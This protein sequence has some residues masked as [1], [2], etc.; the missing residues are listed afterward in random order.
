MRRVSPD[1]TKWL[2]INDEAT[3]WPLLM[4]VR[5]LVLLFV[6]MIPAVLDVRCTLM[7]G[8]EQ[9]IPIMLI[10]TK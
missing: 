1:D 2:S 5:L 9:P 7:N 6:V 8:R 4:A 10:S 3:I